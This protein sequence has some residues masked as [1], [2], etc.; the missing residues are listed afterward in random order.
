MM[1]LILDL[2]SMDC[3]YLIAHLIYIAKKEDGVN[4]K[5][6]MAWSLM[7]NF[8]WGSG[9]TQ[10]FGIFHVDFDTMNRTRTPKKSAATYTQ[11]IKDNGFPYK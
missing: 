2:V 9:F 7:D 10:H 6:Y 5:G 4:V 11:I 1:K 8:E 3:K